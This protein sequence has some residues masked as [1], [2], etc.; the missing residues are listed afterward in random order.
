VSTLSGRDLLTELLGDEPTTTATAGASRTLAMTIKKFALH[1]LLDKA[2]TVVPTRD[3]M[4]VLKNFLFDLT[5]DG[6]RVIATDMERSLIATTKIVTVEQAGTAVFPAKRLLDIVRT[7]G[8]GDV[9]ISVTNYTATIRIGPTQWQLKLQ[10]GEDYPALPQISETIFSTVNRLD[11]AGALAA[12]RYAVSRDAN[13][14]NLM[15]IDVRAGKMTACDGS[16]FQQARTSA[17]PFDLRI[18]IGAV[19]DLIRLLKAVDTDTIDVGESTNHLIFKLGSDVF[20]VNK[21]VAQFPDMEAILLR[22]ALENRHALAV[23]RADLL[24][25]VKRV[26]INADHNTSAIAL[27]LTP[28]H[29]TVSARDTHGNEATETIDAD[30]HRPERTIVVNHGFLTDL[31]NG[32]T[33]DTLHFKLG[34]DTAT[35]RSPVL[36]TQDDGSTG[37]IQQ[38]LSDW[39][40]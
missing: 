20:M 34:D 16:R 27:T 19:D 39:V 36:L 12:V 40:R 4:A 23:N 13:R 31:I 18:P 17:F 7:A 29:I 25:A 1:I 28:G 21:L 15:M 26:R 3:V 10:T 35:R 24:E 32:R 30:W 22:P 2:N 5:P 33:A 8:D 37:V 9:H 14:A 6:L 38:M 11:F